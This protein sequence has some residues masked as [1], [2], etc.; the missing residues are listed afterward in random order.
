MA[1]DAGVGGAG[2]ACADE[3]SSRLRLFS[4]FRL[5]CTASIR[6]CSMRECSFLSNLV[7]LLFDRA[8]SG[9]V[10]FALLVDRRSQ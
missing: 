9:I 5:F 7:R 6:S 10:F 4:S 1:A 2:G 8:I 3:R